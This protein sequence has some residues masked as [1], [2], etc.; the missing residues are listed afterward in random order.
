MKKVKNIKTAGIQKSYNLTDKTAII[1]LLLLP[2]VYFIIFSPGLLTG[3]KMMYGSDWLLGGYP[4]RE[5]ITRQISHF[6]EIPMW[7]NFIFNGL[8]TVTGPY[9]DMASIYPFIRL[10]I[11]THIFWTY[12]F[13][14]G[15]M[16]AGIG[17]YLFL[18]SI[19]ISNSVSLLGAVAYMFAGNLLSTTYAGHE[20]RLL[21]A[22]F[23]PLAFFFWNK[24]II[25]HKLYWFICA[26]AIVG[27]SFT[28]GHFQ[29][30]Y[31]GLWVA[32]AYLVVHLILNR[33]ENRLRNSLKLVFYA[34][35]SVI[36]ALAI[37]AVNYLPFLANL[38]YG[39]RGEVRGYEFA[40]SWAL[41]A[42]EL[43]DL[44]VPQFSGILDNYWGENM[45]KLHSEYFG[46]IILVFAVVALFIKFKERRTAFFLGT[47]IVAALIALGNHT[48]FFK[49]VYYVLPGIKRFRGPSMAFYLVA[50]SVIVIGTIGLQYLF[51]YN[52]K[53]K[54][55]DQQAK[56][57]LRNSIYFIVIFF[58]LFV[59]GF[60]L[61]RNS[62]QSSISNQSK[63]QA[64]TN[65]ISSFWSGV[66]I[67][68]IF[69]GVCLFLIQ[70]ISNAK[71]K[72]MSVFV[73]LTILIVID[74][75]RVNKLFLRTVE[76]P[77]V[78]YS[79]D[80][81]VN[82]LK[83]D[84]TLYRVHPLYYERSNDGI[85]DLYDIHNVGG[86]CPNPLQSYQDFLGAEKTVMFSAPNLAYLNF[87][88]LLNIK[89]IITVPLPD[90]ISRYDMRTQAIITDL[91]NFVNRPE[92]ELAF[93]GRKN[94]I[95][96]NNYALPR[97]F[98]T[99]DYK[100]I[101]D[102]NQIFDMLKDSNFNPAQYVILSESLSI[103][104]TTSE[105]F[106][107]HSNITKYMP[108]R[109]ILETEQNQGG[110]LVLSENYHPD[111]FCKVDGQLTK[112]YPAYHTLRAVYLTQGKHTVEFYY[113]SKYYVLGRLI[114]VITSIFCLGLIA[115]VLY[116]K[117]KAVK[118]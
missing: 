67:A 112:V 2:I 57:K 32:L 55:Y 4:A 21:A 47:S 77:N 33:K 22:A 76:H 43:F 75:W 7:Y 6:K 48:P 71:I 74:Q 107:W 37:L 96:K 14:F 60:L 80:E 8:P 34:G 5:V 105:D 63:L 93:N 84:T 100:V 18:K 108:N 103:G 44:I 85:L 59:I 26:G 52:Q 46:I 109:V 19:D 106:E 79:A 27:I 116:Q 68:A 101:Q 110:F 91:K 86:Y 9:G 29:L 61:S 20:G 53:K 11:P 50:F 35:I 113:Y 13:V 90:D 82:Y 56:R 99:P 83:N 49:L 54:V 12:L 89:Y 36:V 111:W 62:I 104:Q 98:I 38:A 88:S 94:V 16:I 72:I 95:Y 23:F 70:R 15:V 10:V 17:M 1:I 24:G 42:K 115:I 97:S 69:I 114:T 87:L 65:N 117:K 3:D 25:T 64:F 78:Y 118:K 81:V 45:F 66:I 92:F 102:K 58:A 28:H 51:D 39:A 30:T 41:P 31:Y 40:A 73:I